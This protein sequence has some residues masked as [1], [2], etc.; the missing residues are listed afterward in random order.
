MKGHLVHFSTYNPTG[1]DRPTQ[2]ETD[3]T[4]QHET[5]RTIT[6]YLFTPLKTIT[7]AGLFAFAC[8]FALPVHA[9]VAAGKPWPDGI[10]YYQYA[11][12]TFTPKLQHAIESGINEWLKGAPYLKFERVRYRGPSPRV[13]T[14]NGDGLGCRSSLGSGW[15]SHP[16]IN[17]GPSCQDS[18][19]VATHELGHILGKTV[20]LKGPLN[21]HSL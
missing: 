3:R 18:L 15:S 12:G 10:I 11:P 9:G 5:D 17:L 7:F 19:T 14:V 20:N 21:Q 13:V 8:L 16:T 6:M 4:T 1:T 2:Q